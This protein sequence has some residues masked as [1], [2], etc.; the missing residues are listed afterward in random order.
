[1]NIPYYEWRD[2]IDTADGRYVSESEANKKLDAMKRKAKTLEEGILA[3]RELID[4]SEGVAG[5][6]RNGGIAH[7]MELINNWLDKFIEAE[8]S[9]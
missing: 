6:R 8:R 9:I 2:F 4:S 5:L 3:V 1:M 7:W